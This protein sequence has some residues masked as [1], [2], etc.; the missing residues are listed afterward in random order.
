M[1]SIRVIE[2]RNF[3]AASVGCLSVILCRAEEK[4]NASKM[5]T[6]KAAPLVKVK[7]K[8]RARHLYEFLNALP[9]EKMLS[10]KKSLGLLDEKAGADQLKG[11]NQDVLDIQRHALWI[12]S[13]I[14][15]YPFLDLSDLDY[16]GIVTWV[17]GKAGVEQ[18]LLNT[19]PT[20][21]LEREIQKQLFA[22]LWDKLN[23][24]QRQEL[25]DKLDPNGAIKD[26]AAIA[27]LGGAAALGTLSATVLF[28]GFT[29]YTTMAVTI[30][31]VAGFFGVTLPF[32]T[33]VGASSLVALL[34]GPV[35]WAIMGLTA[36]GGVALAGRADVK[37]TTQFICQI[38]T[39]KVEALIA[40]G[41]PEREVFQS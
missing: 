26:K 20:F 28:S 17:G 13:N 9:A 11:K 35:G 32:A 38:H 5:Q 16:H 24:E 12:S 27:A 36:L 3:L 34:S 6:A 18:K 1:A 37:K 22:Q 30:S 21:T 40:A 19:E 8:W 31:T 10:L 41:T 33:Y 25:L 4:P 14:L 23:K 29:F 7:E 15:A 2:R 39:L